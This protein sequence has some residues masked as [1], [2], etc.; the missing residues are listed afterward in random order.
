MRRKI[1]SKIVEMIEIIGQGGAYARDMAHGEPVTRKADSPIGNPP[2]ILRS[3]GVLL[4]R[5]RPT[6]QVMLSGRL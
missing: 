1:V 5:K 2:L 4:S 3:I 6:I